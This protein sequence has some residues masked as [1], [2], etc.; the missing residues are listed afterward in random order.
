MTIIGK[1]AVA[2]FNH[3]DVFAI[4]LAFLGQHG[5]DAHAQ[6]H[7]CNARNGGSGR[8]KTEERKGEKNSGLRQK[9]FE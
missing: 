9:L 3:A 7:K 5:R 6:Q 1:F 4:L 2:A 8:E